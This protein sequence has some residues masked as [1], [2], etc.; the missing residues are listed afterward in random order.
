MILQ[1]SRPSSLLPPPSPPQQQ[2]TYSAT[3]KSSRPGEMYIQ[4]VLL[5]VSTASLR[6]SVWEILYDISSPVHR[7]GG[8]GPSQRGALRTVGT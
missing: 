1:S 7:W 8:G 6:T 4:Y 2:Q 5:Y 3:R